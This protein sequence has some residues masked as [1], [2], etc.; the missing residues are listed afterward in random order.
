MR[1]P[2]PRF[3]TR[4]LVAIVAVAFGG[5]VLSVAGAAV[6]ARRPANDA[7][8]DDLRDDGPPI[9]AALDN[10]GE[11]YR[12]AQD[13]NQSNRRTIQQV[14]EG[15]LELSD[16]AVVVITADGRVVE[17][18]AGLLG[19]PPSAAEAGLLDLPEGLEADDLDIDALTTGNEQSGT[20]GSVVFVAE[21]LA[22]VGGATPV[23]I[24]TDNVSANP[25]G[26]AAPFFL[27][28]AAIALV[29][30]FLVAAYL[31]RRLTRPLAAMEKTA[32]RIAAGD[33][34]AR[35]E[36]GTSRR[37]D[38]ELTGLARALDGMAGELE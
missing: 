3:R 33:L 1:R 30:A 22:A 7:A 14:I 26:R 38:D 4:L 15:T 24:L 5:P 9:A 32:Q 31:V 2:G 34:S 18:V 20:R 29:V 16:G 8:L 25:F 19:A 37:V 21:P 10:L 17:G 28:A 27:L 12:R 36:L 35:V 23:L 6:R 13:E 11:R